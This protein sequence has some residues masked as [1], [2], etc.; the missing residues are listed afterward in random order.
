MR[1]R[2]FEKL[3]NSLCLSGLQSCKDVISSDFTMDKLIQVI[4]KLSRGKCADPA[5]YIRE[6]VISDGKNFRRFVLDMS[7]KIKHSHASPST[8]SKM[9]VRTIK[10]KN[11][12]TPFNHKDKW[13]NTVQSM[14]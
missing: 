9:W 13:F 2:G 3:Q 8:W 7:N 11:G 14:I 5:G 12:S 6:I 10:K 4:N 1:L